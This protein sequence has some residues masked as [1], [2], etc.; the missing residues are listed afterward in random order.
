MN[1]LIVC[2]G[3]GGHLFPGMA[4]G[5]EL[6]ERRHQ[7]LL[8]VSEK[9][10]DRVATRGAKGFLVESLPA[11]GWTGARPDRA[12]RFGWRMLQGIRRTRSIFRSFQPDV[13]VGMGGFSSF[14]PLFLASLSE[15]PACIHESNAI[16]GK[17]NRLLARYADIVAI[18]FDAAKSQ[19]PRSKTVCTGTPIRAALRA[20]GNPEKDGAKKTIL[21]V[22]GSQGARGLNKLVADAAGKVSGASVHWE[23]LTGAADEQAIREVYREDG[24]DANVMAFCHEMQKLYRKA[25]LIVARSGAASLA[26]IAEWGIP[27]I[28]IPFPFAADQHQ[29]ANA[30]IFADAGAA[31]MREESECT[32]EWL[33][34]EIQDVLTNDVRR[35]KMAESTKP[36]RH[37]DAHKK[38]ADVIEGLH[39][40]K[41]SAS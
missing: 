3:T 8:V 32:A 13:V 34:H 38:L 40:T 26:E 16:A 1:V 15:I 19:F 18:G 39:K 24:V 12:L 36:L 6:L 22:G 10:I 25:D 31:I 37:V 21:V 9:E 33:A 23:H 27:S 30:K 5:E 28:L 17:A 41:G 2:G 14:P 35:K 11:V 7:V 29:S 20:T 4:V